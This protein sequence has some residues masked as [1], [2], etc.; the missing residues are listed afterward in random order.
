MKWDKVRQYQASGLV[1]STIFILVSVP[2]S[3]WVL[4]FDQNLND[5]RVS[6]STTMSMAT[7]SIAFGYFIY[8]T[9][10][11]L[12]HLKVDGFAL[13]AHGVLCL[14]TYGLAAIFE[15]Y[16]AYGPVFLLFESSTLFVNIR[17][18]V[19]QICRV[20]AIAQFPMK[21]NLTYSEVLPRLI[22]DDLATTSL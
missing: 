16:H 11:I 12:R 8:D 7:I 19:S 4:I 21:H 9:L 15:V 17:W 18:C 22:Y 6:G 20:E 3:L 10:I 13:L 5:V 2:M 1:P 14:I